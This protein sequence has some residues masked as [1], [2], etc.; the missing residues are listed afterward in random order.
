LGLATAWLMPMMAVVTT[1]V[2]VLR[3]GFNQ[4]AI[5]AQE[6]VLYLHSSA[7]MLGASYTLLT[8]Q[9]VRVDVFYRRFSERTKAWVN[10]VGHV[11]FT[12]P[13]CVLIA[14]GSQHYVADAWAIR[15]SSPEPGGI[16]AIYLL[17]TLIPMMG[18]L[19][20]LQGLSE[21]LKA[22]ATLSQREATSD[23]G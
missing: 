16:P 17:K 7:F 9:H 8:N 20:A 19:L 22:L 5:A 13:V 10:A 18:C 4:G 3:Y 2:V 1:A 6:S 12:F 11:V 15:E 14:V 23:R 21:V